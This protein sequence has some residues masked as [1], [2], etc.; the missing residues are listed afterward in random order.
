VIPR[1]TKTLKNIGTAAKR[2]LRRIRKNAVAEREDFL[3]E[4]N[5]RLVLRM[6]VKDVDVT[7]AIKTIDQ[8]LTSGRRFQRIENA[9][10]PA[11]SATLTKVE[12]VSTETY[13]HPATGNAIT[14]KNV[15]FIDTR[16]TL[17]DAI[18]ARNKKHFAQAD[19]TPFTQEPFLCISSA[20]GYNVYSDAQGNDIHALED[21]FVETKTVME[22]LREHL[23]TDPI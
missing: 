2:A 1:S 7:S 23:L 13:L 20:N 6:S 11:T 18:V 4:L 5:A 3:Q 19:G 17:E 22:I 21:S 16:K 14:F 10:K 9:L 15:Q 12:I 8:Q